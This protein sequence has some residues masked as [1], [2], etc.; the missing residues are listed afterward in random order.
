ME[1]AKPKLTTRQRVK[2]LLASGTLGVMV[3]L[4]CQMAPPHW[5][6]PC[7]LAVKLIALLFGGAS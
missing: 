2:R 4:A 3:G 5:R 1:P 6:V 7:A